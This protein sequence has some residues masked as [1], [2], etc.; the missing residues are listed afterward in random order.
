MTSPLN[1]FNTN[2]GRFYAHHASGALSTFA[3]AAFDPSQ[4]PDGPQYPN[5]SITNV[6]KGVDDDFLPGYHSKLV[7]EYAIDNFDALKYA[8]DKFGR[9]I[10]VGTL[11]SVPDRPHPNAGIGNEIHDWIDA[12]VNDLELPELTTITATRMAAQF[13][14][15]VEVRRPR[16]LF[17]EYTVWSYKYGYAG[18]GDLIYEDPEFGVGFI[19]TKSGNNVYPKV[20][21]QTAAAVMADVMI[22]PGGSEGPIP[23]ADWQGVLHVRPMSVKL[24]KL[25]HTEENWEAFKAA[26][27]LF[28]WRRFYKDSV[29]ADPIKFEKPKEA[30]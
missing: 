13:V 6:I 29:I 11:K 16:F 5:P 1:S 8:A 24:H 23:K 10:A 14:N 12:W 15:F 2:F 18:T 4:R 9:E 28:D 26:K 19:D 25:E 3:K 21:L 20:G 7:A 17:T 22:L 30:K 27:V